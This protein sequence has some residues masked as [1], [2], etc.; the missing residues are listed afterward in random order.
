MRVLIVEDE[1][2]ARRMLVKQLAELGPRMPGLELVGE[3]EDGL[4]A[5]ELIERL[6][7]DVV[8][9]D[10]RLPKLDGFEVIAEL[11]GP[12]VPLVIFVTGYDEYA[13]RAFEVSAV[14]YLLKPIELD[15][16]GRALDRA[17]LLLPGA[18]A[19]ERERQRFLAAL[20]RERQ[21]HLRRVVAEEAGHLQVLAVEAVLAFVAESEQIYAL[22]AEGRAPVRYTLRKLEEQ[23][24]PRQFARAHRQAIVNLDRVVQ[25]EETDAGGVVAHLRGGM[26]FAVSRRLATRFRERLGS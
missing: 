6:R 19:G 26:N 14:A 1:R 16:L 15:R 11:S 25:I 4:E 23:L 13:M 5:V 9:L 21:S 7:P 2:R 17:R 8:L 3:A 20:D 22:T 10:I 18:A 24:D 12:E